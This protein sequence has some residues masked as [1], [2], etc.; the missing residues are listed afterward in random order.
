MV[1]K[2]KELISG[3]L[4]QPPSYDGSGSPGKPVKSRTAEA[5]SEERMLLDI[6]TILS[7][8]VLTSCWSAL[9]ETTLVF[10]SYP[11]FITLQ[12]SVW[13]LLKFLYW[14]RN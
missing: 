11:Q 12:V 5:I 6:T 8:P 3:D 2:C 7:H 10:G 4:Y 9:T 14:L 1:Q 13:N